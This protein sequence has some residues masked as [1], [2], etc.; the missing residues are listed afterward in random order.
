[1]SAP[2]YWIFSCA[3]ILFRLALHRRRDAS[4]SIWSRRKRER[5]RRPAANL[6]EAAQ[7]RRRHCAFGLCLTADWRRCRFRPK[8]SAS[9]WTVFSHLQTASVQTYA[10]PSPVLPRGCFGGGRTGQT[11]ITSQHFAPNRCSPVDGSST[12]SD[13]SRPR[14]VCR[15][16]AKSSRAT[17]HGAFGSRHQ[18]S[19]R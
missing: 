9:L 14:C 3:P 11:P 10:E 6:P 16:A 1:F 15:A 17:F 8:R 7:R 5:L 19:G 18:V 4:G 2:V 13:T 12:K